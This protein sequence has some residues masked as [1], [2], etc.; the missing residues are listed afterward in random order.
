MPDQPIDPVDP[1]SFLLPK[2]EGGPSPL[3]AQRVNAGALL[4]QE[5]AAELPKQEKVEQKKTFEEPSAVKAVQTYS[6]DISRVVQAG[7]VSAVTIAAAEAERRAKATK[8]EPIAPASLN[9]EEKASRWRLVLLIGGS[10]LIVAAL[11]IIAVLLLRTSPQN[12]VANGPTA[13]LMSVD[14]IISVSAVA[15][16]TRDALV[17]ELEAARQQVALPVGL[18]AQLYVGTP[19]T[20][21]AIP[22]PVPAPQVLSVLAPDIP[23]DLVRTILPT[24]LLGVHSYDENQ[25][26][27]VLRV[28]SYQQA[29]SGLL[30]WEPTMRQELAPLFTRHP[31]PR[32]P[33]AEAEAPVGSPTS[34]SVGATTPEFFQTGFTDKII[35]N[36]DARAVLNG[37][38]DL[39]LLWTFLDRNTVIITTNEYTLREVVRRI[40]TASVVPQPRQ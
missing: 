22:E 27:L 1:K 15:G 26:F 25:S 39:L 36:H 37:T 8:D 19:T 7:G 32:I 24:Y 20:T 5:T 10:V 28:D 30:A 21:G 11:G 35:E 29:Y 16:V 40:N 38:G 12:T 18:V 23:Q 9:Q 6:T 33:P 13:P 34:T 2:K 14:Q 3:S 17:T 4:E 31:S